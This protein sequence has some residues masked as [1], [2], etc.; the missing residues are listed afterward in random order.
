[1]QIS[2]FHCTTVVPQKAPFNHSFAAFPELSSASQVRSAPYDRLPQ[3]YEGLPASWCA[4]LGG[5]HRCNNDEDEDGG[6]AKRGISTTAAPAA[7]TDV[8]TYEE[9]EDKKRVK[10]SE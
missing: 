6:G 2:V 3:R 1:M 5:G 4:V 7:D 10:V 8:F 9:K